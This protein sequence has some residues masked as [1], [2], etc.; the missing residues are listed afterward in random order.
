MLRKITFVFAAVSSFCASGGLA[1]SETVELFVRLQLKPGHKASFLPVMAENVRQSRLEA[2][3]VSFAAFEDRAAPDTFYLYER[4]KSQ[5]ALDEH[6]KTPHLQAVLSAAANDVVD[7]ENIS[8]RDIHSVPL[9]EVLPVA[10][11][12]P[13][14]NVGV[15]FK[16]K[17][18]PGV[19]DQFIAAWANIPEIRK[20]PGCLIFSM[21]E[22]PGQSDTFVLFE[23]WTTKAAHDAHLARPDSQALRGVLEPLLARPLMESRVLL[24]DVVP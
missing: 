4:W 2:G 17:P 15:V 14:S 13:T 1:A 9:T 18:G 11:P 3:N 21:H 16:L 23:R 12:E 10:E 6:M 7:G 19:R 22:V 24:R 20:R 8:I 5:A